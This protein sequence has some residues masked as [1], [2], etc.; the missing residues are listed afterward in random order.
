MIGGG[1][2]IFP[3]QRDKIALELTDLVRYS[4]GVVLKVYRPTA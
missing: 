4:S 1:L 3:E 2:R